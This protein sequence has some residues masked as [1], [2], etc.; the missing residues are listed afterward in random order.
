ML[1]MQRP[2]SRD[3]TFAKTLKSRPFGQLLNRKLSES[4]QAIPHFKDELRVLVIDECHDTVD[5]AAMLVEMWGFTAERNYDAYT[6]L[7]RAPIFRPHVILMETSMSRGYGIPLVEQLRQ[8]PCL[9]ETLL[10][11]ITGDTAE[12][13]RG[14]CQMSGFDYLFFKPVN[15]DII[16]KLLEIEQKRQARIIGPQGGT[17]NAY[18]SIQLTV[19]LS[20]LIGDCIGAS[21]FHAL[22]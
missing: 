11:A 10:I 18:Q 20:T 1:T 8:I 19:E 14:L 16:R 17:L 4:I 3:P 22:R 21:C 13:H 12:K 7:A 2:A 9:R 5:S 6:A 15:M